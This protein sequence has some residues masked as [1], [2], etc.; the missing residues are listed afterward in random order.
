MHLGVCDALTPCPQGSFLGR[1]IRLSPSPS[2]GA[3]DGIN[4]TA[5]RFLSSAQE[6]RESERCSS[7]KQEQR[8]NGLLSN[9]S[10]FRAWAPASAVHV[11]M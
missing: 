1:K 4:R 3:T 8:P 6:Q 10:G 7:T 5:F 9:L 2:F 11:P